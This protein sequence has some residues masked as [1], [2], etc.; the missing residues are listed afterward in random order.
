MDPTIRSLI[1]RHYNRV[2]TSTRLGQIET[3]RLNKALGLVLSGQ[4]VDKIKEYGVTVKT[5]NCGDATSKRGFICKHRLGF[6]ISH[7]VY[8]DVKKLWLGTLEDPLSL[9]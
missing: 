7:E 1:F 6:I 3:K 8:E 2:R 5:C 4:I 9:K